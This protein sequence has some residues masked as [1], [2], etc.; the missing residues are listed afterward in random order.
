MHAERSGSIVRGRGFWFTE[1]QRDEVPVRDRSGEEVPTTKPE[2]LS[3]MEITAAADMIR[4]ERG[5]VGTDDLV[6]AIS[7]LLGYGRAGHEFRAR[8]RDVLDG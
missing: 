6:R 8:V 1:R 2:Y 7:R 5:H 4:R 3:A